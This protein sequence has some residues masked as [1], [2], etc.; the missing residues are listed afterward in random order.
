MDSTLQHVNI[1]VANTNGYLL[2]MFS[3]TTNQ[4][5]KVQT[6]LKGIMEAH[7]EINTN[8]DDVTV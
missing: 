5:V 4:T 8:I 1:I 3:K 2:H 7:V 6:S